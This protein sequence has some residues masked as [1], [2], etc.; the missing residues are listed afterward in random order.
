MASA[1]AASQ[2]LS[3][4]PV[5]TD[6]V[7]RYDEQGWVKLPGLVSP[8]TVR[9]LLDMA[10]ARMGEEAQGNAVSPM[11]QPFFNPE[12]SDGPASPVL[13]PLIDGIG[14]SAKTLMQRRKGL[15]VRYFGDSFAPKLPAGRET[16]HPGAGAT[17]YHQD[18]INWGLDRSGGMT[19]WI[20]LEDLAED[21]GTMSFLDGSHR[22]GALGHYRSYEIGNDIR[23]DYPEIVERCSQIGPVTYKAG[24]ATVHS[25]LTVHGAGE[26]LTDRPRWAWIIMANPEDARWTGAPPEAFL[27]D[28][29]SHLDRLDDDARFPLIG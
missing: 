26:N 13:R 28:S 4:R 2:A 14:A 27:T 25:N 1:A 9:V 22:L 3:C 8:E 16:R 21:T 17:Y 6:E 11:Q 15:G 7:A 10:K 12:V 18:F 24:D 19:F 5:T 23:D 20:A 29:M